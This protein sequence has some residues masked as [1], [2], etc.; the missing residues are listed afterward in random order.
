MGVLKMLAILIA[1]LGMA[2]FESARA[3][4]ERDDDDFVL[5]VGS[6]HPLRVDVPISQRRH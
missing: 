1:A 3:T 4:A 6:A 2:A 5:F